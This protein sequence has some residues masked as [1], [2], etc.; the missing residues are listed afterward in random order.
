MS[1]VMQLAK[2]EFDQKSYT[3]NVSGISDML[4]HVLQGIEKALY[5]IQFHIY[6]PTMCCKSMC[7]REL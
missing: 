1:Y 3:F 5:K 7:S 4:G 6:T 2:K